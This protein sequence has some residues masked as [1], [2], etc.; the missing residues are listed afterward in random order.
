MEMELANLQ[1][2][3]VEG[4]VGLRADEILYI[5]TNRHK[6]IFYT[7]KGTYSLYRKLGEIEEDLKGLGFLRAHQSFLINMRYIEKISSYILKLTT[8][9]EISVPKTRYPEVKR[10]YQEFQESIK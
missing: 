9:K 5:E 4:S 6:N 10:Q 3:F 1:Y 7:T 8:G 2:S